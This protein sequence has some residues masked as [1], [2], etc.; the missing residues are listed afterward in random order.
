MWSLPLSA[1]LLVKNSIVAVRP[2][3]S[4]LHVPVISWVRRGLG[5]EGAPPGRELPGAHSGLSPRT[6]PLR[7]ALPLPLHGACGP[8]LLHACHPETPRGARPEAASDTPSAITSRGGLPGRAGGR[9]PP[10]GGD[11]GRGLGTFKVKEGAWGMKSSTCICQ[12]PLT[13]TKNVT[14]PG[15]PRSGPA[16]RSLTACLWGGQVAGE[17]DLPTEDL[18]EAV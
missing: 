3:Q 11:Q 8:L 2:L 18:C 13:S 14:A 17:A 12:K 16:A 7:G 15:A 5:A 10:S 1:L 9:E 6:A 4:L